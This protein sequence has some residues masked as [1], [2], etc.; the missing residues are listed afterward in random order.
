VPSYWLAR[1]IALPLEKEI[2]RRHKSEQAK[3]RVQFSAPAPSRV[4]RYREGNERVSAKLR[5]R[6]YTTLIC[7]AAS[8]LVMNLIA[9]LGI[10]R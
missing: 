10:L 6:S 5:I 9:W 8:I 3:R 1:W 4:V 7:L 2:D